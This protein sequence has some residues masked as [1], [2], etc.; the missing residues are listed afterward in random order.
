MVLPDNPGQWVCCFIRATILTTVFFC[1]T[2]IILIPFFLRKREYFYLLTLWQ[3]PA[4]SFCIKSRGIKPSHSTYCHPLFFFSIKCPLLNFLESILKKKF[5]QVFMERPARQEKL[6]G[7][8]ILC[9]CN[10]YFSICSIVLFTCMQSPST[11]T[12]WLD[13]IPFISFW[14]WCCLQHERI[15]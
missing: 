15:L 7:I 8:A 5:W 13:W 6:V 1:K 10:K 2:V 3:L 11:T 4:P 14:T 9:H 12:Q